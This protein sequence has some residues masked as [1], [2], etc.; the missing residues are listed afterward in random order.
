MKMR[1]LSPWQRFLAGDLLSNAN[2]SNEK[3]M[4]QKRSQ[5]LAGG[6]T[7]VEIMI[8]VSVIALLAAIA[9]PGF[10]RARKRSQATHVLEDLRIIDAAMSLY[11]VERNKAAGAALVF[12]DLQPYLK[13]STPLYN[14][15]RD[16]L[17]HRYRNFIVDQYPQMS[18]RTVTALSD[19]VD[20]S[21]WSPYQ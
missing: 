20:A 1:R 6:F 15:G 14:T 16:I 19:V 17:G 11:A 8:V 21:F 7:L 5:R 10:L 18:G 12:S 4:T 9:V 2:Y 3:A 13:R